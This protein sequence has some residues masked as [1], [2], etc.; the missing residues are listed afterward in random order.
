MGAHVSLVQKETECQFLARVR[1]PGLNRRLSVPLQL[2]T[3]CL[4]RVRRA[5]TCKFERSC[6]RR[7]SGTSG[8]D[9]SCDG[10]CNSCP[11]ESVHAGPVF[12]VHDVVNVAVNR[13][14]ST[15]D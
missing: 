4:T 2:A 12:D 13:A 8:G 5:E 7:C 15:H 3:E 11:R 6:Y 1:A 10:S 9:W 14:V